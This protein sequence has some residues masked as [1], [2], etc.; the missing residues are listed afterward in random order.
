MA[1]T[2]TAPASD[3]VVSAADN[4]APDP[5]GAITAHIEDTLTEARNFADGTAIEN[6]AQAD[7]VSRL[8]DDLRKADKVADE[9][10]VKEA[11]PFNEEVAAIQARYN[12]YIAPLKNRTPGKIPLAIEALKK[13]LAPWLAAIEAENA[14]KAAEARREAEAKAQAAADAVRA[15]QAASDLVARE[16]AEALVQE[17]RAAE[18]QAN[19][20]E[21]T[22]AHATGG[23]RAVGLRDNW[24]PKLT[25]GQAALRH[26]WTTNRPALEAFALDL[27]KTDVRAG[28]RQIPGFEVV[29]ERR[30]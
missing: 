24:I 18:T 8:I 20:A 27:A 17:A 26:Y 3:R 11:A 22:K 30:I 6:Q 2:L 21:A 15:A 10:R 29:N 25:D 16:N 23:E 5:F 28:K 19:R 14:R 1:N 13:T 9:A 12:V 4:G 7:A